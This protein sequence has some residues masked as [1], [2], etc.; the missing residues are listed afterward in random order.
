ME[1]EQVSIDIADALVAIDAS[2]VPFKQFHAGAGPHGEPQLVRLIASDL[3]D[4]PAYAG[5]VETSGLQICSFVACG[6]SSLS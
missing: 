5:L 2:R 6:R 1:L 3:N 4:R